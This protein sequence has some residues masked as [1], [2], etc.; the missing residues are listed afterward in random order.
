MEKQ[1]T[2]LDI[3][4]AKEVYFYNQE[5]LYIVNDSDEAYGFHKNSYGWFHK[6]NFWDYF[7]SSTMLSYFTPISKEQ[8]ANLYQEWTA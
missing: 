5:T 1:F 8:A 6:E 7:E 2:V 4:N 3:L